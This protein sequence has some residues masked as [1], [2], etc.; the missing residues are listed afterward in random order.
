MGNKQP[1]VY[2]YERIVPIEYTKPI[3]R[4]TYKLS[5][6]D[7]LVACCRSHNIRDATKLLL[8]PTYIT[9]RVMVEALLTG[10]T[11]IMDM[12]FRFCSYG[13]DRTTKNPIA[14]L[15]RGQLMVSTYRTLCKHIPQMLQYLLERGE[16]VSYADI[17][18]ALRTYQHIRSTYVERSCLLR[19]VGICDPMVNPI[20]I[21]KSVLD[22]LVYHTQSKHVE[23]FMSALKD[24]HCGV[25]QLLLKHNRHLKFKLNLRDVFNLVTSKEICECLLRYG[26][27]PRRIEVSPQVSQWITDRTSQAE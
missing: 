17:R 24:R 1:K 7:E 12:L 8:T 16:E 22:I 26:V 18:D 13:L 14:L 3:Q 27:R 23:L 10:Y 25:M 21:S 4:P 6:T 9:D 15:L 2:R 20:I 19:Y 5:A 11:D